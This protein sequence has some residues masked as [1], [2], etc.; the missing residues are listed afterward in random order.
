MS[1]T[2]K[3][4]YYFNIID[5]LQFFFQKFYNNHQELGE[6]RNSV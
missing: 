5:D 1:K 6:E 2:E 3:I 4:G